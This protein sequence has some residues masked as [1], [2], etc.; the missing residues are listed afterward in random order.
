M[1]SAYVFGAAVALSGVSG[2]IENANAG[3]ITQAAFTF[4]NFTAPTGASSSSIGAGPTAFA[5]SGTGSAFGFHTG[6]S[7]YSTPGGNG[8]VKAYS[9]T[10]FA[11]N[12]YYQFT[13]PT[14]GIKDI[15]VT[16]D[17][18]SSST[19]PGTFILQY[20]AD[21]SSF[22]NVGGYTIPYLTYTVTLAGTGTNT[23]TSGTSSSGFSSGTSNGAFSVSFD[24]STITGLNNNASA[25][26]RL[27]DSSTT[28]ISGG[29]VAATG[30]DRVDNFVLSG[31]AVPEPAS[32]AAVA[33]TAAGLLARRRRA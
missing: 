33:A 3:T 20:S 9:S 8:S 30:T 23:A 12:D 29:T 24:L 16:F 31:N 15:L 7:A 27:V 2:L 32:I 5:A 19:G 21:G 28:S 6:T 13:V 25:A 17:Q 1:K 22:A 11:V 14:T 18:I 26:F 4:E 10:N